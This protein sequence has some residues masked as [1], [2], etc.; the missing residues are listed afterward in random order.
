MV[1]GPKNYWVQ[2]VPGKSWFIAL[3]MYG[4]LQPWFDR[5]WKIGD[6]EVVK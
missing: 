4:P 6:P 5:S 2:T 3:R 1:P